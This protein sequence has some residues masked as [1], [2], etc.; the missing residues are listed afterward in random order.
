MEEPL[1]SMI[2]L[3]A[4]PWVPVGWAACDGSILEIQPN[5]ILYDL[6]GATYG[7]DGKTTFA[8]PKIASPVPG[9]QYII[10][11]QGVFPQRP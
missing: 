8:L 6:I 11:T 9:A 1:I 10:A 4:T 5:Y 2:V 7:G 3:F